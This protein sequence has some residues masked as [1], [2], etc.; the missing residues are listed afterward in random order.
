MWRDSKGWCWTV[1]SLLA[2]FPLHGSTPFLVPKQVISGVYDAASPPSFFLK[3]PARV[4]AHLEVDQPDDDLVVTV[5]SEG[6][7]RKV[8]GFQ[9]GIESV[10]IISEGGGTYH[11]GISPRSSKA[12]GVR[13]SIVLDSILAA[14]PSDRE[15]VRAEDLAT[16]CKAA[17]DTANTWDKAL[18]LT[19]QSLELW[20]RLNKSDFVGRTHLKMGD[21]YF[22]KALWQSALSEYR[23]AKAM[24][25]A[26]AHLRCYAEATNNIGLAALNLSDL[27]DASSELEASRA[28]WQV[29]GYGLGEAASNLNLGL[30]YWQEGEWQQALDKYEAVRQYFATH[31]RLI[32]AKVLNNIGLVYLSMN[33]FEQAAINFRKATEV[34]SHEREALREEGRMRVN[35]G[36]A[37]MF[38]GS[39]GAA[40]VD[41]R[42]AVLVMTKVQDDNGLADA[43]SNLGQIQLRRSD[44]TE[45]ETAFSRAL[46]LYEKSGDQRGVSCAL[47]YLGVLGARQGDLVTARQELQRA[48]AIRLDRRLRDEAAETMYQMAIVERT[49]HHYEA[50]LHLLEESIAFI[51]TLRTNVAG[52]P[53][54]RS[55]FAGKQK[56]SEYYIDTLLSE[57]TS[58]PEVVKAAFNACEQARARAL[59][60]LLG[61]NPPALSGVEPSLLA[62]RRSVQ[63]RLNFAS[64]RLAA[65]SAAEGRTAT[66]DQLRR[67]IDELLAE[68]AEGGSVIQERNE[69]SGKGIGTY[70]VT[71]DEIQKKL[72]SGKDR[73]LEYCLGDAKSFLW[74][75]DRQSV[76][77]VQLPG[78]E[79][80]EHEAQAVLTLTGELQE[81]EADPGK[82]SAYRLALKR[83]AAALHLPSLEG[84][85]PRWIVV[86]DGIL[87]RVPFAALPVAAGPG[88]RGQVGNA[89]G[90]LGE[91][92]QVPSASVFGILKERQ[93]RAVALPVSVAAFVDPVFD[94][95]DSRVGGRK[96]A[97]NPAGSQ[98]RTPAGIP[99]ARLVFPEP[100]VAT[101]RRRIPPSRRWIATGFE[102]TKTALLSGRTQSYR[103]VFLS[104]HA[105]ADDR[106]PEL[107]SIVLSRVD[108]QGHA[109]DGVVHLYD[110]YQLRL[111]SAIVI[112]SGCETASG[113]EVRGEG[114]IGLS[115][116]FLEAGASGLLASPFEID[117]EGSAELV[118]IF[119]DGMLASPPLSPSEALLGARRAL[120][121]SPRWRD[122]YYWGTFELVS[123]LP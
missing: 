93:R 18:K 114:L 24:C 12:Q 79:R 19:Q 102:A 32:Y 112:L 66:A 98:G 86:P 50:A 84:P 99:L 7:V 85:R 113:Q 119:L 76:Q 59:V 75:I 25:D 122:P 121:R 55:Y 13:Y 47:H 118:R 89:L 92:V 88:G 38:M 52:E 28:A 21:I 11:V 27:D 36:R 116:G 53:L 72:L 8:D 109:L 105:F 20:A 29:L 111:D 35:L 106:Q 62:R 91:V 60:D 16:E 104:T 46:N 95:L 58:P 108:A 120:A 71:V 123:G 78:R 57:G 15:L 69:S 17:A 82:E 14:E 56:Y 87:H 33:E 44:L 110:L 10:T 73:L 97:P 64:N 45:A 101:I 77:V 94:D 43:F 61:E 30:L 2:L 39:L 6:H 1:V 51:E 65:L 22:G 4:T 67:E 83:L 74:I 9:F 80:I 31:D 68:N 117:A 23:A 96:A 48:L 41:E 115:R 5:T 37:R 40:L 49:E 34:A 100:A 26:A 81:R 90:L 54:R 103:I 42:Q 63:R 107:S 70:I 3:L